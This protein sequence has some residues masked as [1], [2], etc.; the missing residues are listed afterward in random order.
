MKLSIDR[1]T[2]IRPLSNAQSVVEK[3]QSMNILGNVL[4]SADDGSLTMVAT[5]NNMEIVQTMPCMVED[6]GTVTM[7]AGTLHEIIRRLP[8]DAMVTL[9]YSAG[10]G[11]MEIASGRSSFTL[12]TLSA[13]DFPIIDAEEPTHQFALGAAEARTLIDHTRF[14]MSSEE[15][16]FYLNGVF[17]HSTRSAGIPV[18]RAVATDGHRL[19][20]VEM[21]LPDGA[22]GMPGIIVPRKAVGEVHKLIDEAAT[23]IVVTVSESRASF[24]F[25]DCTLTTKLVDGS[26]PEYERV[27]PRNNDREL[28]VDRKAFSDAV[29]RVA[30]ISSDRNSCTV[31]LE[32]ESG[33]LIVSSSSADSGTGEEVLEVSYGAE[34]MQIGFNARYLLDIAG[35]IEGEGTVFRLADS[36]APAI[37]RDR[38][39]ESSI[40]VLMPVRV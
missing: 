25:G 40:Y 15:T 21:P 1:A 6:S 39:D 32:I 8:A 16:R 22:D 34:K 24:S 9:G 29:D 19:A 23:D 18:M 11:R 7:P 2:L 13:D 27:I 4:L 10:N 31:K 26:F 12:P 14:A 28:I 38:D 17:M 20:R 5:D 37:V 36:G 3:R 33:E 35:Q 30:A